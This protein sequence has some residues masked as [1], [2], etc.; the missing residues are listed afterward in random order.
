MAGLRQYVLS[1][2]RE[3]D[4]FAGFNVN[5]WDVDPAG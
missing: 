4:Y 5:C 3:Q 1:G 2:N